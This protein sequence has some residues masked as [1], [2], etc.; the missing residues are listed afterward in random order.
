MSGYFAFGAGDFDALA[1]EE[2]V[3]ADDFG[4]FEEAVCL[5]EGRAFMSL[6]SKEEPVNESGL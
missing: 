4:D 6:T 2:R 3:E 1:F 5:A